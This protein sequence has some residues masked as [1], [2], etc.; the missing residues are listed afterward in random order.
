M[1]ITNLTNTTWNIP[2]GWTCSAGYGDFFFSNPDFAEPVKIT[3]N[4]TTT[5]YMGIFIG[6]T[7]GEEG[8]S[9]TLAN[10]I[11]FINGNGFAIASITNN[12]GFTITFEENEYA[13][14]TKTS[15]ISWLETNGTQVVDMTP[16]EQFVSQLNELSDAIN[17]KA[18]TSGKMTVSQMIEN[19]KGF[20]G[21]GLVGYSGGT[22]SSSATF[23]F[24]LLEDGSITTTWNSSN[25][26][27]CLVIYHYA[28]TGTYIFSSANITSKSNSSYFFI[29]PNANN[30]KALTMANDSGGVN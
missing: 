23:K 19:V 12:V 28:S 2:A 3:I 17:E 22:I 14:Y 15:L 29:V 10:S 1:A 20:S 21:G 26:Y 9:T 6:Y 8:R 16:K 11:A 18:K 25:K 30:W 5:N 4:G 24:G 27:V 7:H 13:D